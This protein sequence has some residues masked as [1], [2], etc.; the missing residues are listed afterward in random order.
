MK[1]LIGY[2]LGLIKHPIARG[3]LVVFTGSIVGN[4]AAYIYHLIVGRMLGPLGYGELAALFSLFYLLNVPSGVLQTVLTR[5]LAAFRTQNEFGRAKSLSLWIIWR[6]LLVVFVGGICLLPFIRGI[7]QFLH[8]TN[9]AALFFIYLTSAIGLLTIVQVSLLQ[10]FQKFTLSMI[11]ANIGAVLRVVGGIVGALFG[12]AET[13]LA[14]FITSILSLIAYVVPL[15]F[16]YNA[17]P[18]PANVSKNDMVSFAAP[19]LMSILGMTSLYSTDIILAKHYLSPLE[20]GYYAALSILGKII[21]FASS[22]ISYVL[23]PIIAERMSQK[24][25]SYK[26]VYSALVGIAVLSLGITAGYFL[27]PRFVL[28]ILFGPSYYSAAPYLGWFGIFLTFYS[29]CQLLVTTFLGRGNTKVWLLVDLAAALQ[30]LVMIW[31]HGN[32]ASLLAINISVSLGLF[33]SLLLY[34]RYEIKDKTTQ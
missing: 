20:A 28:H 16:V 9:P 15:R 26:L 11:V 12:V 1:R 24:A 34:Y 17:S 22:N 21:F 10:A 29:L 13:V 2:V 23:F 27:F 4:F 33:I 18:R 30:V 19:S 32:I 25:H 8:I 6:L 14:G 5:Y 3:S 31:F 7:S